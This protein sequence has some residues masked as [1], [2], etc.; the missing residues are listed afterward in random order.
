MDAV[1]VFVQIH[2]LYTYFGVVPIPLSPDESKTLTAV[3]VEKVTTP[4]IASVAGRLAMRKDIGASR[5]AHVWKDFEK[6]VIRAEPSSPFQADGEL[7]GA[8]DALE[9]TPEP[10]ALQILRPPEK[11][12]D[13]AAP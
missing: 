10:A 6:V 7:L 3:A 13:P 8:T 12:Q 5:G 9:I 4:V 2:D 11:R 1:A